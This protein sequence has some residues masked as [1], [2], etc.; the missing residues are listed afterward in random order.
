[1]Q[2]HG[3]Q[4]DPNHVFF[5]KNYLKLINHAIYTKPNGLE[6]VGVT[7]VKLCGQLLF[8]MIFGAIAPSGKLSFWGLV[9]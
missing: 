1:M 2:I 4:A 9:G 6:S 5:L 7:S 8:L 3:K